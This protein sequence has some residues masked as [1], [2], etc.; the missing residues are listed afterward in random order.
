MK[1]EVQGGGGGGRVLE[2]HCI[3][4]TTYE[5]M[6]GGLETHCILGTLYER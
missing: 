4:G 2:A 5:E 1:D 6:K 3:L